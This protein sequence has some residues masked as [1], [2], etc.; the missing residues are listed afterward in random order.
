MLADLSQIRLFKSLLKCREALQ[1]YEDDP[2]VNKDSNLQMTIKPTRQFF[3]Q[4]EDIVAILD[5]ISEGQK[6]SESS[7]CH[8]GTVLPRWRSI[9][10]H[11]RS[12]SISSRN[13][14]ADEILSYMED[15]DKGWKHRFGRQIWPIHYVANYLNPET[16]S[17]EIRGGKV[18]ARFVNFV[19]R[20]CKSESRSKLKRQFLWYS[21]REGVFRERKPIWDSRDDPLAFWV[22]AVSTK[23]PQRSHY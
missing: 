21:T 9:E 10:K 7:A 6:A 17:K 11:L 5:M 20:Y 3:Q 8:V 2:L 19:D 4:L 13:D 12:I 18:L 14:F 16:Q 22:E 23:S 1:A 15:K